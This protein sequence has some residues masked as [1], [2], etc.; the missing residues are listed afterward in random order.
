M[1]GR[2]PRFRHLCVAAVRALRITF[3]GILGCD[4]AGPPS[5]PLAE[6]T[7]AL[8]PP[9]LRGHVPEDARVTDY[10]IEASLEPEH[11][12][13]TGHAT[14]TWHNRTKRTVSVLPFH[15][16]MN[17]FRAEDS[18]WMKTARGQHRGH[19][20]DRSVGWGYIDVQSVSLRQDPPVP[21]HFEE[22]ADPS[23]MR[24][25]LPG[26]IG[27][28]ESI[29]LD[30]TFVTQLP[31]VF[32][33]TGYHDDFHMVGQWYP[34]LAVLDPADG[35]NAHVFTLYDEFYADFGNY[36]VKLDVPDDTVVGASGILV[37]EHASDGRK[38]VHYRA[39]MVHDFA[40]AADPNFVRH[41]GEYQGIRIL[42]L[43]R[44]EHAPHAPTHL[45]AQIDALRTMEAR[46][47]PYPWST[48]T[49]VHPPSGAEAAG[50]MEYPTLYTTSEIVTIPE[51]I[52]QYVFDERF[53][54]QFTT[55]HE[56]GHQYFQGLLAS[57]EHAQPWLDEGMNTFSN[58]L[59][60][61]DAYGHDP[62]LVRIAG[63]E[64]H[65]S[66][67]LRASFRKAVTFEAVDQA[68][69]EFEPSTGGYWLVYQKTAAIM[70]TLRNLVGYEGFDRALHSYADKYRFRH[71]R[72][73]DL[74][75]E[76]R[77][78]LGDRV[79]LA[80]ASEHTGVA[81]DVQEFLHQA[82]R[83]SSEMDFRIHNVWNRRLPIRAGWHRDESGTLVMAELDETDT[84]SLE[85]L[86]DAAVEGT[87]VVHRSGEFVVP[88]ELLVEFVDGSRELLVWD[89]RERTHTFS[90]EGRRVRFATLDP[91][92][93]LQLEARRWDN[94]AYARDV[95]WPKHVSDVPNVF[96]NAVEAVA[97]ALFGSVGP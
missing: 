34:K 70:T 8:R 37:D 51:W 26:S 18:A 25:E 89:A 55:I 5:M 87:V 43:L 90:F 14:I 73:E 30:M 97:L 71:P 49:I 11:H 77:A 23:V 53:S 52:R 81:L 21:L 48:I 54:G 10:V 94:T 6:P 45:S 38:R 83:E 4:A 42:Q 66:D 35:W 56:F 9:H 41:V 61:F 50:G 24:V 64:F 12:R 16:Y 59:V 3:L 84:H 2:V 57:N 7:S 68:A 44:P 69:S 47:G 31:K 58:L 76:L 27:P 65:V 32:A 13:I 29:T 22:A 91:S 40:W 17:A 85:L 19:T 63:H 92:D 60:Y 96:G 46:F 72:G 67:M 82:L 36:D 78:T 74:E 88:V 86:P 33:R 1:A 95:S 15:L 79:V 28:D 80:G 93:K 62:W 39:E 75:A 20:L